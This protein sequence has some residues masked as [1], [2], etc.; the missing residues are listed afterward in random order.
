[1]EEKLEIEYFIDEPSQIRV[2]A[3]NGLFSGYAEEYVNINSLIGLADE[4]DGFPKSHDSIIDFAI[5]S[6][7]PSFSLQFYCK[8][9]TGHLCVKIK[10]YGKAYGKLSSDE[11]LINLSFE[12]VALD[13]FVK[14]LK[15]INNK[16]QGTVKLVGVKSA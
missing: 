10:I 5:S 4:L 3:S 6:K 12:A 16:D 7:T 2:T 14:A 15:A 8:N 13:S 9:R 1:M 11:A